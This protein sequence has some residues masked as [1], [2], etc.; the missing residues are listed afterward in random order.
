MV[1][2]SDGWLHVPTYRG[3]AAWFFMCGKSWMA[4]LTPYVDFTDSKGPLVWLIY[5]IG[6]LISPFDFHGVFIFEV[7]F[8]WLTFYVLY[9]AAKIILGDTP[10]SLA[11]SMAMAMLYFYPGLHQ[12]ILIE[13]YCHLF[14]SVVFYVLLRTFYSRQYRNKYALWLGICSGCTLMMKYSYFFTTGIPILIIFLYL[15]LKTQSSF[16]FII[17]YLCGFMIIV[18]PFIS[19]LCTIGALQ[20]FIQEYF[21]NTGATIGNSIDLMKEEE[22]YNRREWPLNI[23]AL[24]RRYHYLSEFIRIVL[25]GF[26]ISL[27]K[28]KSHSWIS[29]ALLCWYGVSMLLFSI[30]E[31][32][33]YYMMTCI[34]AFGGIVWVVGFIK[35]IS[36]SG[37]LILSSLILSIM[38]IIITHYVYSEFHYPQR[39]ILSN[40]NLISASAEINKL[41]LKIGRRPTIT[42]FE[43]SDQGETISTN[44]IAG[45]KYWSYQA[46]MT[47]EMHNQHVKD[48]IEKRPDVIIVGEERKDLIKI[49]ENNN[50][51]YI[52][53]RYSV[54]P[55][56]HQKF[57]KKII[58]FNGDLY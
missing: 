5:G 13:D 15:C 42:Y 47:N 49:I 46:G 38:A 28:F 45:I 7:L 8:Y 14:N 39:D 36:I 51:V 24:I 53:S 4:G 2:S 35:S 10:R 44:T 20:D 21:I 12:E 32:A 23:W 56:P 3:D 9:K 6:Y 19:Y 27:F 22:D 54:H 17:Y 55:L 40:E 33:R 31:S 26:I 29:W 18:L 11:S 16:K 52:S 34:F 48:I 41:E 50:Y 25:L 37:S 57:S 30:T 1:A 58:Y 43:C